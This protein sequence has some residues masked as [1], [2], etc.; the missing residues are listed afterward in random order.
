MWECGGDWGRGE[1]DG[2]MEVGLGEGQRSKVALAN[3]KTKANAWLGTP[4]LACGT[5]GLG[6]PGL[7]STHAV[8]LK[9]T[10]IMP[11]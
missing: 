5:S 1:R 2:E 3:A 6:T 8:G 4:G 9:G 11:M 10:R 7:A